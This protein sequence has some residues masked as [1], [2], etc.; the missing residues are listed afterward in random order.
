MSLCK[1]SYINLFFSIVQSQGRL[2]SLQWQALI[3]DG[4]ESN[5]S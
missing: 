1:K 5:Q 4:T 2:L 3:L